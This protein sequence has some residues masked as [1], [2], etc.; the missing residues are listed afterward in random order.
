MQNA[1]LKQAK[2]AFIHGSKTR[3]ATERKWT[4]KIK[5]ENLP[6]LVN[7]CHNSTRL[8]KDMEPAQVPTFRSLESRKQK[9]RR[10]GRKCCL[11]KNNKRKTH[12]FGKRHEP[13]E[14]GSWMRFWEKFKP[15]YLVAKFMKPKAKWILEW[16]KRQ[17]KVFF[18]EKS[19]SSD[20]ISF[21]KRWR[22]EE[23]NPTLFLKWK[24]IRTTKPKFH[25]KRVLY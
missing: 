11:E 23:E 24:N 2:Q 3:M 4:T 17:M 20:K 21:P 16:S 12:V 13:I 9:E 8:S 1:S 15:K 25:I 18:S 22:P 14:A 19:F 10:E 6:N 5:Q 7:R